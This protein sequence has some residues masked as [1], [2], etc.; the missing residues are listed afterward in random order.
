MSD[1]DINIQSAENGYIVRANDKNHVFVYWADAVNFLS[2]SGSDFFR[3][4]IPKS[5]I[6]ALFGDSRNILAKPE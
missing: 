6:G 4:E 1:I 5:P 2:E 3:R